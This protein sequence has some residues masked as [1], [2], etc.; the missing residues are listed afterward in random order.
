MQ[1]QQQRSLTPIS[2][3]HGTT[4]TDAPTEPTDTSWIT[5]ERNREYLP[6]PPPGPALN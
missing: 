1:Q 4:D 2:Q 5:F 6:P 3:R